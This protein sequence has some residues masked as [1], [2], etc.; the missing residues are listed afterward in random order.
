MAKKRGK[1]T[2][3]RT[4][5]FCRDLGWLP[6]KVTYREQLT[7]GGVNKGWATQKDLFGIIDIIAIMPGSN[8]I[9][10][11]QTTSKS[12]MSRRFKK[13]C[14]EREYETRM[15]CNS[16]QLLEIWGWYRTDEKVNG[17]NWHASRRG[18]YVQDGTIKFRKLPELIPT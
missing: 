9:L 14:G 15:W 7:V 17:R 6:G 8:K 2:E 5:A 3:Q 18:V 1:P 4:L 11:I 13:M 12:E 10:G 16:T